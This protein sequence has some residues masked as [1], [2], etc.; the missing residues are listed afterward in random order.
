MNSITLTFHSPSALPILQ[1]TLIIN[2]DST[3]SSF[4]EMVFF[5]NFP[6]ISPIGKANVIRTKIIES[7]EC[8]EEKNVF[9]VGEIYQHSKIVG[10]N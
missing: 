3:I 8:V 6:L 9:S 1:S 7:Y 10:S 2:Q 5:L 4:Y